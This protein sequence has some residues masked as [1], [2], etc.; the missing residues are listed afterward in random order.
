MDLEIFP[1]DLLFT[2]RIVY[3][4][5]NGFWTVIV[6]VIKVLSPG[7]L[8]AA[9][10]AFQE[11]KLALLFQMILHLDLENVLETKLAYFNAILALFSVLRHAF[12]HNP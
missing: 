11:Y 7:Q 12:S 2:L 8:F 3:A 5:G 9:L 4:F 1:K 10:L 6:H